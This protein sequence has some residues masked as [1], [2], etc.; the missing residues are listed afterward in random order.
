MFPTNALQWFIY[1]SMFAMMFG[2]STLIG[3]IVHTP[4]A[5]I[6]IS[7]CVTL[8]VDYLFS[9]FIFPWAWQ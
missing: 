9:K 4:A 2:I 3:S 8:F 5:L 7:L 1:L 6:G